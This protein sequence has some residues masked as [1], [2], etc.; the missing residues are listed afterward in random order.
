MKPVTEWTDAYFSDAQ[1]SAA[2]ALQKYR[3]LGVEIGALPASVQKDNL[4]HTHSK[5]GIFL[6]EIL[7]DNW[8]EWLP[9]PDPREPEP[10]LDS[11]E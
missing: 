2:A 5:L 8:T 10:M 11:G 3:H 7:G 4:D 9:R 1:K 6:S